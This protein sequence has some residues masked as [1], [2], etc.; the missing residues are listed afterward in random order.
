[1]VKSYN[2]IILIIFNLPEKPNETGD[3]TLSIVR[4]MLSDLDLNLKIVQA[5]RIG[6]THS[7]ERPLVI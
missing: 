1:V 4:D 7:F 6:K 5:K 2:V 3:I